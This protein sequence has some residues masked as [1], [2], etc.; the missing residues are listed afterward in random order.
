MAA[1]ESM[2]EAMAQA[3]VAAIGERPPDAGERFYGADGD[4]IAEAS[5]LPTGTIHLT[6][7]RLATAGGTQ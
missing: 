7:V 1:D 5:V 6:T 2:A 3:F 4:T